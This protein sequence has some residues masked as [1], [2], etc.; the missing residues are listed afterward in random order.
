MNTKKSRSQSKPA[1]PVQ[2]T[3][4]QFNEFIY[5]NL[6]EE[7]KF[8][9]NPKIFKG[10]VLCLSKIGLLDASIRHGDGTNTSA[11]DT[12]KD[13]CKYVGIE[14]AGCTMSLD[15]VYDSKENRK[16]IFNMGMKPNMPE[17]A[18]NRKK[19]KCG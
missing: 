16:K 9:R 4:E 7:T 11:L 15:G 13:T 10:S 17:N 2:L 18:R 6:P 1:I 8:G 12:L 14:L 19:T 5:P 3:V